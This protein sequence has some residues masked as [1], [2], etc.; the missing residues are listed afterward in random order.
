MK[1]SLLLM[2]GLG[3]ISAV[4]P[5]AAAHFL[6]RTVALNSSTTAMLLPEDRSP[7]KSSEPVHFCGETM[8][9]TYPDVTERWIRTISRQA[10]MAGTLLM[11]K[12]RAS[13][14]F[15]LIEPILKQY[16]IPADFKFLPLLESAV[17][18]RAVSRR[19]AAGFWQL[20]PQTA[21]SLGLTVSHRNDE[22]FD[23]RKATHAACRY[24][25]ELHKQL[26]SWMLVATA[27]NAGPNYIS[28][29]TRQHPTMHPMAL[30]YR[31]AETKAY[32][33]QTMAIK[34]LLTHPQDYQ[35]YLDSRHLAALSDGAVS[36]LPAERKA[37]LASFD[38][39]ET[40]IAADAPV[41]A[42]TTAPSVMTEPVTGIHATEIIQINA[43][44]SVSDVA[45]LRLATRSLSEGPLVEGQ[46]CLFQ[47]VQAIA[48][49]G[50]DFSVGDVIQAHIEVVD[51]A[52]GQ[53]FLRTD[54]YTVAQSQETVALNFVATRQ[55]RRPGVDLPRRLENWQLTWEPL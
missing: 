53:V 36:M 43:P 45:S 49:N 4:G 47:V 17:E 7:R 16:Q 2:V 39:D 15:P 24:L 55:P 28:Q 48:I 54:Q 44:A 19:G 6:P 20:M 1:F 51:T 13:V 5:M 32:L 34:E 41:I 12:R 10:A 52:S 18:N 31:A 9:L 23:L 38:M 14:V 26:G 33:F 11:L 25:N 46:L 21:Q 42:I 30:P 8:P 35:S 29:L 50:R 3:L 27:Y 22:R 40:A 37:I